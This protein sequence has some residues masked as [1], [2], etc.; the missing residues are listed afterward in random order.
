M[1]HFF[2]TICIGGALI[3]PVQTALADA[4][5]EAFVQALT[6]PKATAGFIKIHITSKIAGQKPT[7]NYNISDLST[8]DWLTQMVDPPNSPWSMA[9]GKA[10]YVSNDKGASWKKIRDLEEGH[11]PEAVRKR[12]VENMK[13]AKNA[14]CG[15]EAIN[16]VPHE[17]VEAEYTAQG[18]LFI[19]DK[20]WLHPETKRIVKSEST[21]RQGNFESHTTQVIE[22]LTEFSFPKL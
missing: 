3:G 20:N 11:S 7:I 12:I 18:N 19:I 16:G 22:Y 5:L 13:T 15:T 10:M 1:R 21:M 8:G 14:K 4:C 17:T 6:K 2:M 9:M